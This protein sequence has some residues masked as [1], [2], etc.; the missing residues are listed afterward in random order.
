MFIAPPYFRKGADLYTDFYE[1]DDHA[2][3]A[4]QVCEL[5]RP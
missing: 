4:E 2:R 3:V 5:R 1:I